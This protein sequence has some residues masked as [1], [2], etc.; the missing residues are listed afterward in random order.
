M[1]QDPQIL[2]CADGE[3]LAYHFSP[4]SANRSFGVMFCGGFMSDMT[5]SKAL[6]LEQHCQAKGLSF[7]RFDYTGHGQ[8]SGDFVAGTIGR[9]SEDAL[10]AL[11]HLTKGPM[12]L[13][14]SSMGGWMALLTALRRPERVAGLIGIAAAPDFTDD[15]IWRGMN[16]AQ[17][18]ALLDKGLLAQASDYS[19]TPYRITRQLI[20][21]AR[22]H[23]LLRDPIPLTCP[24]HLIHGLEDHDVPWETS[25]RIAQQV[26]SEQVDLHF[27]KGGDHRLSS[28]RDLQRLTAVLDHLVASLE[29]PTS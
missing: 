29:A 20:E 7:L 18:Q 8:S 9:W 10:Y 21:E 27:I 24:I 23:L 25:L 3:T 11:D 19:E 12:I 15:L 22:A 17:R 5:G 26:Q 13:V 28:E 6:H 14:G 4:G 16:R 1:T 2:K